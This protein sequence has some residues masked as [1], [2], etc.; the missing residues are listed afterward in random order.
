MFTIYHAAE[1]ALLV[2]T[3]WPVVTCM[4]RIDC[5]QQKLEGLHVFLVYSPVKDISNLPLR[6]SLRD[7]TPQGLALDVLILVIVILS[8]ILPHRHISLILMLL[9]NIA[10]VGLSTQHEYGPARPRLLNKYRQYEGHR[11]GHHLT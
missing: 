6:P 11:R 4:C 8:T 2:D 7:L 10:T 1:N 9:I 3:A 5:G